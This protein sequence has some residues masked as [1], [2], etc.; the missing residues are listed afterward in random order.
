ME[1]SFVWILDSYIPVCW[2]IHTRRNHHRK[3]WDSTEGHSKS[4][5]DSNEAMV[6]STTFT[7]IGWDSSPLTL[8][9]HHHLSTTCVG[10]WGGHLEGQPPHQPRQDG[11]S[12]WQCM[13]Q[14]RDQNA[15]WSPHSGLEPGRHPFS[16]S[17]DLW[18]LHSP[19]VHCPPLQQ[20]PPVLC[21]PAASPPSHPLQPPTEEGPKARKHQYPC[22]GGWWPTKHST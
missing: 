8:R 7:H 12:L 17:R 21:T 20:E 16:L 5:R 13:T 14:Q 11:L 15:F 19:M 9:S 18:H 3:I 2:C 4:L 22:Y 6:S 1:S 10:G